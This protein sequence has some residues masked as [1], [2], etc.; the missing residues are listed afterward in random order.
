[1]RQVDQM[2]QKYDN[3]HYK[4]QVLCVISVSRVPIFTLLQTPAFKLQAIWEKYDPKM[5]L[6]VNVTQICSSVLELYFTLISTT[7][8]FE[9]EVILKQVSDDYKWPRTL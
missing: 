6:N 2:T 1:M 9:L 5:T 3:E 8:H 4:V 7:R